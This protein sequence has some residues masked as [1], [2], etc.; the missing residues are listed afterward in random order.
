[1]WHGKSIRYKD[2]QILPRFLRKYPG[3]YPLI[4]KYWMRIK[5]NL[6]RILKIKK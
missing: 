5:R 2:M 4:L 6:K 1:M 3:D